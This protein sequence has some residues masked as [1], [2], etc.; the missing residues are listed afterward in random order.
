MYTTRLQFNT[1]AFDVLAEIVLLYYLGVRKH[2]W[3]FRSLTGLFTRYVQW[4]SCY[5]GTVAHLK[6]VLRLCEPANLR[7]LKNQKLPGTYLLSLKFIRKKHLYHAFCFL[8]FSFIGS[9]F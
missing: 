7:P 1:L 9:F 4:M 2:S 6:C 8:V 3:W 5:I